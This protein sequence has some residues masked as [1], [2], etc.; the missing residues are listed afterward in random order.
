M[1]GRCIPLLKWSVFRGHVSFRGCK[2]TK[3]LILCM[4]LSFLMFPPPCRRLC[5]I[6]FSPKEVLELSN[7]AV[8]TVGTA[9]G[10]FEVRYYPSPPVDGKF[11]GESTLVF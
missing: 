9:R 7:D 5:N 1:V 2:E 10:L 11:L 4:V 6:L 8:P 3:Y